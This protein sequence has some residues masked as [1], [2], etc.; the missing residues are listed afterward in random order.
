MIFFMVI[1]ISQPLRVVTRVKLLHW[2]GLWTNSP[3]VRHIS[4]L[5]G[6]LTAALDSPCLAKK[7]SEKSTRDSNT[8]K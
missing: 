7:A 8:I 4:L 5:P 1:A 2:P 3:C 6:D